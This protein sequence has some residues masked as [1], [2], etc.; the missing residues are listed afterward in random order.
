MIRFRPVGTFP[1]TPFLSQLVEIT[2]CWFLIF[3]QQS[4]L[5]LA[6]LSGISVND[7]SSLGTELRREAILAI[8]VHGGNKM[9]EVSLIGKF[10]PSPPLGMQA[11]ISAPY[12]RDGFSW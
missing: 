11:V 12:Y 1:L 5:P 10:F 2:N 6:T 9:G 8:G 7:A 4:A 3:D